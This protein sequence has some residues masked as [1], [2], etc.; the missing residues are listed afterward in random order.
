MFKWK[1]EYVHMIINNVCTTCKIYLTSCETNVL[2]SVYKRDKESTYIF[3][4]SFE[5]LKDLKLMN[6]NQ[7]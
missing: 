6:A 4:F 3:L 5:Y 7:I 2:E 1:H